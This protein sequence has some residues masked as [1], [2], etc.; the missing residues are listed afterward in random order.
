MRSNLFVICLVQTEPFG[1]GGL[2]YS[3]DWGV[4][5]ELQWCTID[6][7]GSPSNPPPCV[8]CS[9]PPYRP[10]LAKVSEENH[11][12]HC[13]LFWGSPMIPCSE[14]HPL[15]T[16]GW[17]TRSSPNLHSGSFPQ[18]LGDRVVIRTVVTPTRSRSGKGLWKG[19]TRDVSCTVWV[20]WRE[21][22]YG[23]G[24]GMRCVGSHQAFP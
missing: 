12:T 8:L 11:P 1:E 3:R 4:L 2:P 18:T 14:L 20:L 19:T 7:L 23:G 22:R 16:S 24:Y 6:R 9:R 15:G 21:N 17:N 10:S 13:L 5:D